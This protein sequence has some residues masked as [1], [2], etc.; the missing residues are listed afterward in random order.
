M[1][2]KKEDAPDAQQGGGDKAKGPETEAS[3]NL[4]EVEVICEGRLGPLLLKKG[5]R[6]SDPRYVKLLDDP[7]DLV[8][9]FRRP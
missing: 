7:R 8:R 1:T 5:D 2:K 3:E 6:T 9:A 4:P